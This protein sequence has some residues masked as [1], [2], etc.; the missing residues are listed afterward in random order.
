MAERRTLA[1]LRTERARRGNS[2]NVEVAGEAL[3]LQ[4]I[5]TWLAGGSI[6]SASVLPAVLN[7]RQRLQLLQLQLCMDSPHAARTLHTA[8]VVVALEK[9]EANFKGLAGRNPNAEGNAVRAEGRAAQHGGLSA[10]A[11]RFDIT[12]GWHRSAHPNQRTSNFM[13]CCLSRPCL[14]APGRVDYRQQRRRGR[15]AGSQDIPLERACNAAGRPAGAGTGITKGRGVWC[16]AVHL[17]L[18]VA[19]MAGGSQQCCRSLDGLPL[20]AAT[21]VRLAPTC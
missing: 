2:L 16:N 1:Q 12:C 11:G 18:H 10:S 13:P 21:H 5:G 14:A 19:H 20:R 6:L 15:G 9:L 4:R 3:K 7:K 8:G 17:I